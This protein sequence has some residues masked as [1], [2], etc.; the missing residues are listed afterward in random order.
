VVED[1]KTKLQ[2]VLKDCGE[3]SNEYTPSFTHHTEF[4]TA[5][6]D[7]PDSHLVT[8]RHIHELNTTT[9]NQVLKCMPN[10]NHTHSAL[11]LC[12]IYLVFHSEC[13]IDTNSPGV[14]NMGQLGI[15]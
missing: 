4:I 5:T 9:Y 15:H 12:V 1:L 11:I 7:K 6:P 8:P 14:C 13:I 3:Y 2:E 10:P